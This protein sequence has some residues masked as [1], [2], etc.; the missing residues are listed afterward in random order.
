MPL[1]NSTAISPPSSAASFRS[2]TRSPG[3]AVAAVLFAR[4]LLFDE[5]DDRLRVGE[6]VGRRA[7]DRIG[8]RVAR[9]LPRLAAVDAERRKLRRRRR[10]AVGGDSAGTRS[11]DG[12]VISVVLIRSHSA[13]SEADRLASSRPRRNKKSRSTD[14]SATAACLLPGCAK[15]RA[16]G[17]SGRTPTRSRRRLFSSFGCKRPQIPSAL[18]STGGGPDT[19]TR[20]EASFPGSAVCR[21]RNSTQTAGQE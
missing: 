2:A 10:P 13:C 16:A 15:E 8:D 11:C 17:F 9:L 4:L 21:G 5:I 20:A 19:S 6:R 14:R 1:E 3:I 18:N 12:L 7:E